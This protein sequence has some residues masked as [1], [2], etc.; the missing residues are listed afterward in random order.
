MDYTTHY[1]SPIGRI[2]LA[3]DGAALVG[4]WF[5]GQKYY[6]NVLDQQHNECDALPFFND[7]RLWLDIY[8][9]G[10][11]PD[12]TP[13]LNMRGSSFRKRVW[14]IL[15]TIPYGHTMTYGEISKKLNCRSAM[16]VGGAVGHNGISLIVP[17]HRVV[18]ADGRLCGYAGGID[19]KMYLLQ[20]EKMSKNIE[21]LK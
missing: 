6:A 15:L 20:M 9:V 1:D 7:V 17:C 14:D 2:T 18:G 5:E 12:F 21:V 8:F 4:L 3:S 13:L 16:A 19:K 11:E 10:K